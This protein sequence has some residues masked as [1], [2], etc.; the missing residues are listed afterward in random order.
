[1]RCF[2]KRSSDAFGNIFKKVMFGKV[3]FFKLANVVKN[4][5]FLLY[6]SRV[7]LRFYVVFYDLLEI[8]RTL[9]YLNNSKWLLL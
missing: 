2:L 5:I 8:G 9:T 4:K 6:F 7:L 3:A 1:M